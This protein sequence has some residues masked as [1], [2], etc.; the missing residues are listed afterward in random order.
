MI[1]STGIAAIITIAHRAGA[2]QRNRRLQS[3]VEYRSRHGKGRPT[4]PN[5]MEIGGQIPK[6][7]C[8]GILEPAYGG[9]HFAVNTKFH[10]K[11]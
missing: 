3:H 11:W 7:R 2:A 4:T 10:E 1:H 6:H 5:W 8:A 9:F